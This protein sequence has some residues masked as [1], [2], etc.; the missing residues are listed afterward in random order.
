MSDDFEVH[1]L[2]KN[3]EAN[4]GRLTCSLI[5]PNKLELS[6]FCFLVSIGLALSFAASHWI[7]YSHSLNSYLSSS[8]LTI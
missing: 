5:P 3:C 8:Y 7:A 6:N 2:L 1:G 4:Q